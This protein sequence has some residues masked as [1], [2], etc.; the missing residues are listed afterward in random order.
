MGYLEPRPVSVKELEPNIFEFTVAVDDVTEALETYAEIEFHRSTTGLEADRALVS[1]TALSASANT[2]SFTDS[3]GGDTYVAWFRFHHDTGPLN[4]DF[5]GP[6]EYGTS[7][8][9][10]VTID[11]LRDEGFD[12]VTLTDKRAMRLI[13]QAQSVIED[14]TGRR[15][16][17]ESRTVKVD[18]IAEHTLV[19]PDPII[20]IDSIDLEELV[21]GGTPSLTSYNANLVR[22]YNRHLTQ[23]ILRPDDREFPR[24]TIA[25]EFLPEFSWTGYFPYTRQAMKVVGVFGYTELRPTDV[26]GE[27]SDG[28]QIPLSYGRCPPAIKDAMFRLVAEMIYPHGSPELR[29]SDELASRVKSWKT[30]RQSV[31]YWSP[32]DISVP[33]ITGNIEVDKILYRYS[34][35]YSPQVQVLAWDR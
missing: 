32:S 1:A 29:R 20:R 30:D 7:L 33:V 4:S 22:V 11:D 5:S 15:F 8:R 24:V 12:S 6:V 17:A 19:L 14:A 18:S 28:S 23:R 16:L 25:P 3:S 13:E 34:R 10:Y 9:W 31:T 21:D 2:Y 35:D 27:T 26:A